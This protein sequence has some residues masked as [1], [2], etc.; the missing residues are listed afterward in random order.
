MVIVNRGPE[1]LKTPYDPDPIDKQKL[2]IFDHARMG[3]YHAIKA[4]YEKSNTKYNIVLPK[5]FIVFSRYS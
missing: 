2:T 3:N 1:D 5:L 4:E